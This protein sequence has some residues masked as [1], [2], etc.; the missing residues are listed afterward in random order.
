MCLCQG[1]AGPASRLGFC[2]WCLC[3][4]DNIGLFS[5]ETKDAK[6]F[7]DRPYGHV[8]DTMTEEEL[9]RIGASKDKPALFVRMTMVIK[10][11]FFFTLFSF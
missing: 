7:K 6:H 2:L 10:L 9:L 8:L 3:T 11:F 5:K 1:L 4:K